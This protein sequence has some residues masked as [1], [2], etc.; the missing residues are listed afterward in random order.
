LNVERSLVCHAKFNKF[1]KY[2][3]IFEKEQQSVCHV[4]ALTVD[5]S[6]PEVV[7]V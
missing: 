4:W 6:E 3:K 7:V 5:P 2:L 1:A